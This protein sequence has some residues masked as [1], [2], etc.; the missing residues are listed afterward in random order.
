M[1]AKS[2]GVQKG[3]GEAIEDNDDWENSKLSIMAQICGAKFQQNLDLRAF[4]MKTGQTYLA[5]DNPQDSYYGIGL[6]RNSPRAKSRANFKTN[7][8]GVI[9]MGIRDGY[10]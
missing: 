3:I 9:L 6:S 5:E 7:H 10:A 2:P 4:L 1:H 8:L